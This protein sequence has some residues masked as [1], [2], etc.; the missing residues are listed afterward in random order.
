MRYPCRDSPR[1]TYAL[2]S[3]HMTWHPTLFF[4]PAVSLSPISSSLLSQK[5]L[6]RL[7]HLLLVGK[8]TD[9]YVS[10]KKKGVGSQDGRLSWDIPTWC[11]IQLLQ[12]GE[13]TV[14]EEELQRPCS[15]GQQPSDDPTQ[16]SAHEAVG[17]IW[18][19]WPL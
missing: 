13:Q 16:L 4:F 11:L 17:I 2:R 9:D 5:H 12:H 14:I 18:G 19:H 6:R 8:G 10:S 7:G 1:E 15:F 3:T